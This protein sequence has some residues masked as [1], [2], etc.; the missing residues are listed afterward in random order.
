M[1]AIRP[2]EIKVTQQQGAAL[3]TVS[4]HVTASNTDSLTAALATLIEKE[5]EFMI[6][7]LRGVDLITSDGLG[8]LIRTRKSVGDYGGRL[9]LTGLTGNV[10]DVF[11]MTRLDKI[12]CMYD[13]PETAMA[14]DPPG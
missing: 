9:A 11:T 6:V 13:S 12:F 5:A 8:A 7:D 1:C 14:A 2:L 4:G 3:V 10:L